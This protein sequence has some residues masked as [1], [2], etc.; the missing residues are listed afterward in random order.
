MIRTAAGGI[1]IMTAGLRDIHFAADNRL[2]ATFFA[3]SSNR[4][5]RTDSM[6][7]DGNRRHFVFRGR[8]RERVMVARP[9]SSETETQ[10]E[11]T[12]RQIS[13]WTL[14]NPIPCHSD[15]ATHSMVAHG[16]GVMSSTTRLIPF[17]SLTI[18][19]EIAA[20][21]NAYTNNYQIHNLHAP[22][23]SPQP[24]YARFI[25]VVSANISHHTDSSSPAG[26]R[27]TI[28]RDF[29]AYSP[30]FFISEMRTSSASCSIANAILS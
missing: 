6:V 19:L 21:H 24:E 22:L 20:V 11:V 3:A 25:V 14:G 30:A 29:F 10:N 17:T 15:S 18:R 12:D 16:F 13:T 4:L 1:T 2:H 8:L 7:G 28:T 5:R 23:C 9:T 27:R 26:V